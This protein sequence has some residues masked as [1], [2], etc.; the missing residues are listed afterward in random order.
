MRANFC[1]YFFFSSHN[2]NINIVT[3][4]RLFKHLLLTEPRM[5]NFSENFNEK[6]HKKIFFNEGAS[7]MVAACIFT[8]NKVLSILI[9]S[10]TLRNKNKFGFTFR[11]LIEAYPEGVKDYYK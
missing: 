6:M 10:F 2:Y 1:F 3:A 8:L 5:N 7:Y 11:F 4:T 9:L